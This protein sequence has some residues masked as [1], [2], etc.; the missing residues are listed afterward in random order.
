MSR[1]GVTLL[2][3]TKIFLQ[4]FSYYLLYNGVTIIEERFGDFISD[5]D[6]IECAARYNKKTEYWFLFPVIY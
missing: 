1:A 2:S 6:E 3:K 5:I 4:T